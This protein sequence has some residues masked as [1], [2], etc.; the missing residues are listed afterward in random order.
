MRFHSLL[1]FQ[2]MYIP[3]P[4]SP[5]VLV[6]LNTLQLFWLLINLL[7]ASLLIILWLKVFFLVFFA[8]FCCCCC[9][10][11]QLVYTFFVDCIHCPLELN[12]YLLFHLRLHFGFIH[13]LLFSIFGGNK[14]CYNMQTTAQDKGT[15][16]TDSVLILLRL[17]IFCIFSYFLIISMTCDSSRS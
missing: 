17:F 6:A 2:S 13:F 12:S 5:L 3:P 4:L 8:V 7:L 15:F 11:L 16:Y 14:A 10:F 9:F 1:N